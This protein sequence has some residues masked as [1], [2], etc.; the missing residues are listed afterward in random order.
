MPVMDAARN[1]AENYPGG[2][3]ALAMRI[4]KNPTTFS[5]E[6]NET[7]SAKLGLADAV[8]ASKRAKDLRVLN[9]F[10][11]EMSCT[12]LLLPEAL[13]LVDDDA[14]HLVSKL[15]QEFNDTVRAFVDAVSDGAVTG[16]ELTD[17]R[18][19]WADLQV[20]GQRVVAH[21]AALHEEAK[22]TQLRAVS[23]PGE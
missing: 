12:V 7:G 20:A 5:H 15:A 4:E 1:M 8:R 14:L 9:A 23:G 6:L 2:A 19:Q 3:K 17:I 11:E 13:G 22:P 21:A 16:N 10:A 18:R